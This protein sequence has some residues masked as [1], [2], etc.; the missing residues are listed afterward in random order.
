MQLEDLAVYC[1]MILQLLIRWLVSCEVADHKASQKLQV[2]VTVMITVQF[3]AL[4]VTL[5]LIMSFDHNRGKLDDF[6][7]TES[8]GPASDVVQDAQDSLL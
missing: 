7:L 5:T 6:A 8:L 3:M 4:T 2:E 1:C